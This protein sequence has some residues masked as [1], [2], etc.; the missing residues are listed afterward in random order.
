[1]VPPIPPEASKEIERV[2]GL[3]ARHFPVYDIRVKY[4]VVE[5]F[6]R[7]DETTLEEN[8]NRMR[9][10]M[11]T[12]GYIPLIVY[13][14]GEHII[15]V[16]RRPAVR[17]RSTYVNL[18]LLILTFFTMLIAGAG[19]WAG[20]KSYD[21]FFISTETVVNGVITF[22]L[23]LLAIIGVHEF[24]HYV[25]AR[26]RGV[27]ASLPF[28]IPSIPP[29]GTFGAVISLR[30]PLPDKKTL[31][32]VGVAG[33]LAGLMI[34]LPLG[35]L[36]L[37]LTNSEA[38]LAPANV[39]PE[40]LISVQFPLLY[41]AFLWIVPIEGDYLMH[42]TAFA[43]WVGFLVTALNLLPVGQL[44]GGHI[45][46]ALLGP[47][48]KY[49]GWAAIA[50]LAG[51][52]ITLYFGWIL[53]VIIVLF[54][55]ARHPPPLNDITPLDIKRKGVGVIAFVIL[56]LA[57][58][59]VPMEPIDADYSFE[60]EPQ[61]STNI[62]IEQGGFI[63]VTFTVDNVGNAMNIIEVYADGVPAGWNLS[64]SVHGAEGAQFSEK[65]T[66]LLNSS[67]EIDVVARVEASPAAD[68]NW[69]YNV[70]VGGISLNSSDEKRS[71]FY[72][73]S[74]SSSVFSYSVGSGF[75]EVSPD[76]WS[77]CAVLVVNNGSADATITVVPGLIRPLSVDVF[78]VADGQ[79]SSTS[80]ELVVPAKGSAYFWIDAYVNSIAE[81]GER[82][83]SVEVY[84][85]DTLHKEL[86]IPLNV[87]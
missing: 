19:Q 12:E 80:A 45:A 26:R 2:K 25:A 11:K 20:Y 74:V 70:S 65:A 83:V 56:V 57:F 5:F 69:H 60:L 28:F 4:D 14:K 32:E 24:G 75:P 48:A 86:S 18:A 10:D 40:G 82:V 68:L 30:D 76:A 22:T 39:G 41:R 51:I 73:M 34:A 50:I 6:V 81:P 58:V 9:A 63:D 46:R 78:V 77:R 7:I 49:L 16:A 36:G 84:Y 37:I 87:V 13:D 33:P 27:A 23:P 42:P 8:F 52:S 66:V 3:V 38:V 17:Y 31:L 44:D 43:A 85:H 55:G 67:E 47:R 15:T 21:G 1:M 72:D 35:V 64:F 79:N 61:G 54:L 29:F 62:T 71:L 59:P 53:L